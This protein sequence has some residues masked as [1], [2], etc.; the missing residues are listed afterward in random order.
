MKARVSFIG[1][2]C[3]TIE[4]DTIEEIERNAARFVRATSAD[5]GWDKFI[6]RNEDEGL[7]PFVELVV[8]YISR[9]DAHYL[10]V[11]DTREPED[12]EFFLP[13][14]DEEEGV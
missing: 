10:L 3:A 13:D 11:E 8:A 2:I 5:E 9:D 6:P 7:P 1:T 4:G 14:L 12:R